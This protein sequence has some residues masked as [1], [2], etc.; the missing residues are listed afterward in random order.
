MLCAD[1]SSQKVFTHNSERFAKG[2][3]AK[4]GGPGTTPSTEIPA[5]SEM[6]F[7]MLF[8]DGP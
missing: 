3:A 2:P 1:S 7:I 5:A 4:Q 8:R 6:D